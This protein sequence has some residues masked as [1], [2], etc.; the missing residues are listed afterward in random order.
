[1]AA[2]FYGIIAVDGVFSAAGPSSTAAELAKQIRQGK[3]KL[4][5]YSPDLQQAVVEAARMCGI[6]PDGVLVL[7][8]SPKWV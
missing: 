5:T 1:M 3:S 4:V 7:Q 8:S 2:A 6:G